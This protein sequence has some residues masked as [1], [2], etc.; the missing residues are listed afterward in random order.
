MSHITKFDHLKEGACTDPFD[1][2]FSAISA[3]SQGLDSQ[4]FAFGE[5]ASVTQEGKVEAGITKCVAVT[6]KS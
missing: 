1:L 4:K 5:H 2:E 6:P 3:L